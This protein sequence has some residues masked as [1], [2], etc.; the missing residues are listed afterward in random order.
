MVLLFP[1]KKRMI[2]LKRNTI[3][4]NHMRRRAWQG[5]IN[6]MKNTLSSVCKFQK[7]NLMNIREWNN[8]I[9]GSKMHGNNSRGSLQIWNVH[10]ARFQPT[11]T[12]EECIIE[13]EN[14]F[15]KGT[16]GVGEASK[17]DWEEEI[18]IYI[19]KR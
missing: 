6:K 7:N 9:H 1:M 18:Y 3:S 13:E 17:I 16:T 5:V 4:S 2:N 19:Y 15:C 10:V 12:G 14:K 11:A 8:S